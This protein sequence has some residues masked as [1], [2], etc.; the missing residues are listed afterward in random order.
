MLQRYYQ[1]VG[2]GIIF[3]I[4]LAAFRQ[5]GRGTEIAGTPL[6][7]GSVGLGVMDKVALL[8]ES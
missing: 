8:F 4:E 2:E 1:I 7:F 3:Y 6:G 5:Y